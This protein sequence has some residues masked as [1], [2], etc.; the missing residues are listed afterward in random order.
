MEMSN[1]SLAVIQKLALLC[2]LLALLVAG[3]AFAEPVKYILSTPGV[4]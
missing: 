2:G 1:G 3:S 4:V